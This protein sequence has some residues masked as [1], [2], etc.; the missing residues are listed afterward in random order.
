MRRRRP[1][2]HGTVTSPWDSDEGLGKRVEAELVKDPRL[3]ALAAW[4][5]PTAVTYFMSGTNHP[6]E[7]MAL[8][9]R[10][11]SIGVAVNHLTPS[12][13]QTL[14]DLAGLFP[15]VFVDSGAFSEVDFGPAGP[16]YPQPIT[17]AE[18][19]KRLKKYL[20][21]AAALGKQA[22][23][24]AP[25]K[26]ADQ[27]GTLE[28]LTRYAPEIAEAAGYGANILVPVQKGKIDMG[29]FYNL[30]L[31]ILHAAGV[32]LRQ[33]A[34]A[35]PLKKDATSIEDLV[36]FIRSLRCNETNPPRIHFLGRGLFSP[37]YRATYA[38]AMEA[39]PYLQIT[40]D[41]VRFRSSAFLGTRANPGPFM[42][43]QDLLR[44]LGASVADVK[45][46]GLHL[47]LNQQ[48]LAQRLEA[49]EAGWYDSELFDSAEEQL[50]WMARHG[51]GGSN[52]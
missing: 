9:D 41:S 52:D 30:Q 2:Y 31:D 45:R 24:V 16:V 10:G 27:E 47:A 20:Q 1:W 42:R 28:R 43:A 50:A 39:C 34:P 17:D 48:D 21:L 15:K 14:T 22:Y 25:D 19:R 32:R 5:F 40:A 11:E 51:R 18:W 36:T 49:I 29:S 12:A 7:I 8:A 35:V 13:M 6:A 4:P 23:L 37:D 38:A 26:I 33:V 46:Y 3:D 44:E